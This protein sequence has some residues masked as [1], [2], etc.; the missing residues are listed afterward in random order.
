MAPLVKELQ[1]TEQ[2]SVSVCV[3]GQ[4]KEMLEPVL[5]L[6][7]IDPEYDL[8]ILKPGQDLTDIT[9]SVLSGLRDLFRNDKPDIVMVHGDTTTSGS[10]SLAAFYA[11]IPVYHVEAGLRTGDLYSPW[12]EEF[13]RRL[14][15]LLASRH[16]PPTT[17]ARDNLL[18]EGVSNQSVLVTGNTVIDA[19]VEVVGKLEADL[20]IREEAESKL[21]FE[22]DVSKKL[23][24]VT[25][26][27]RESFGNELEQICEALL[28]LAS[29]DDVQIVYPVHLNPH[30]REPVFRLLGAKSNIT[31]I[32]PLDYLPF[33]YLLSKAYLVL[34]DSGGIQEEAPSLGKPV[35]V[36]REKTERQEAI[37]AGTVKLVGTDT[38]TIVSTT[39][40]LLSD[41]AI[42]ESMS[43]AINPYGDGHSSK[44]I[45][46]DLINAGK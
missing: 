34:T 32:D 16:Y 29:R 43:T 13:N 45:V 33:V 35:I 3:T 23:L 41:P 4:H 20:K 5:R 39:N 28:Q 27:R 31:L 2:V 24:L 7:D 17:K 42:Y 18:D 38:K 14:T 37:A 21:G 40:E 19:L 11:G 30:V 6:F 44:M 22:I 10:A 26:H 15:G 8:K 36:L 46:E 25:C 1:K 9:C 12:P